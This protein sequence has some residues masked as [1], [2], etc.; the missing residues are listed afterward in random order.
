MPKYGDGNRLYQELA[1]VL[2]RDA[3]QVRERF[4]AREF[5]LG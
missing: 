3:V 2:G 4:S 1:D 5:G